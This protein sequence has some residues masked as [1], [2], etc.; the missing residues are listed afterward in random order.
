MPG[1]FR[2]LSIDAAGRRR[3]PVMVPV[4]V[5]GGGAFPLGPD[6]VVLVSRG[7]QG[8][9]LAL[10][11]VLACCG[12]PVAVVGRAGP[13]EDPAMMRGLEQLRSA[14]ARISL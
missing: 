3:V 14:G 11:Q 10:A 6:D 9:G 5:P 8:A 2:E 7:T 12:S 4:A 13:E 1:E